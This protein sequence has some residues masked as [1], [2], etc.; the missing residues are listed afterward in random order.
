MIVG[1]SLYRAC[2]AWP[3]RWP[4]RCCPGGPQTQHKPPTSGLRDGPSLRSDAQTDRELL[5]RLVLETNSKLVYIHAG[6]GYPDIKTAFQSPAVFSKKCPYSS[7]FADK[8]LQHS[9]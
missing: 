3:E 4:R 7:V 1:V 5:C 9:L 6:G 2:E 8:R